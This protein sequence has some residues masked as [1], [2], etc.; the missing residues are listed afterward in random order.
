MKLEI[1]STIDTDS[2][3]Y[4]LQNELST[5]DLVQF[6][7]N[8]SLNLTDEEKFFRL[9]KKKADRIVRQYDE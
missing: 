1:T 6:A 9:L 8:L 7:L 2:L 3:I 4:N 5:K